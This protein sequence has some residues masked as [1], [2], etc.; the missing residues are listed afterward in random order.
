MEDWGL[1][2]LDGV[3]QWKLMMTT[4]MSQTEDEDVVEFHHAPGRMR[5]EAGPQYDQPNSLKQVAFV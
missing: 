1:K 2:G 3:N 5:I 4:R